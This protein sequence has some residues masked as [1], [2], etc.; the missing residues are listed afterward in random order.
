MFLPFLV[1]SL[2]F[3]LSFRFAVTYR[4]SCGASF[5]LRRLY[6]VLL[7]KNYVAASHFFAVVLIVVSQIHSKQSHSHFAALM[8]SNLSFASGIT[9]LDTVTPKQIAGMLVLVRFVTFLCQG[10]KHHVMYNGVSF[11]LLF[12]LGSF[13]CMVSSVGALVKCGGPVV[14]MH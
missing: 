9:R 4:R 14:V 5:Y 3:L 11:Y 1:F 2:A 7:Q 6:V 12:D 13:P 8:T 10:H